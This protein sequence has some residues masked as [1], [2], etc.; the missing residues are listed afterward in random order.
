M[1][2]GEPAPGPE[3]ACRVLAC[4]HHVNKM[5]CWGI[6]FLVYFT[7]EPVLEFIHGLDFTS[8]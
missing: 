3:G 4:F 2:R 8:R 7:E 5:S 6:S 1:E